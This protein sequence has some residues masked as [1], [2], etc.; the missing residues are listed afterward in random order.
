LKTIKL[1]FSKR[2]IL[3]ILACFVALALMFSVI[4]ISLALNGDGDGDGTQIPE[5]TVSMSNGDF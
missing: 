4:Q 1:F 5:F 2:K 3:S